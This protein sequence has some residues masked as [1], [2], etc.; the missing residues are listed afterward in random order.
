MKQFSGFLFIGLALGLQPA[1]AQTAGAPLMSDHAAAR[2]LDQAAWGPTPAAVAQLQQMGIASWLGAQFALSTSDLPAQPLIDSATGK[3]NRDL[4]PVQAAFFQ[5]TVAQPDQLRQRVAFALSQM[6]VVSAVSTKDAYAFPPYWRLFRDNAFG[7]YRDIMS[8]ITLSPAMGD[9]L[10]MANNNKGDPAKGTA[11][12]ENY[13]RELM[14]LFTIGLTQLHPDGSAVLDSNN[15]PVPTYT[16]AI[17]TETA[18][19]DWLDLSHGAGGQSK[20]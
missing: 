7:N 16:Q 10:N 14:Q 2:F 20:G 12:N 1:V 3:P 9:Y 13:A 19:A 4:T 8:A 5:N 18:R 6:W 11:A 17:I 15:N